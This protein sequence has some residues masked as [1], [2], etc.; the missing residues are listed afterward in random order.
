MLTRRETPNQVRR[1][2]CPPSGT[3]SWTRSESVS[4][5]CRSS[6]GFGAQLPL[7]KY[8][9]RVLRARPRM[10]M[11]RLS[12]QRLAAFGTDHDGVEHFSAV[13]VLMHHRPATRINHMDVAPV[14]DRHDYRIEVETFLRQD[15]FVA[16][17][18]FL[19]GDSAQ[20]AEP[21]ELL[22]PLR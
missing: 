1:R 4:G 18:R 9:R 13:L 12:R 11:D 20:N 19:I 15:V 14:N 22:Q 16:L 3:P 17:G 7:R 10:R 5:N 8:R 21:H 6:P 2:L